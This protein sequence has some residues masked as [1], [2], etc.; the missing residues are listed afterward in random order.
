MREDP[1]TEKA[2]N[3]V[4][5]CSDR[6]VKAVAF[7]VRGSLLI[8]V[9]TALAGGEGWTLGLPAVLASTWLSLR[10]APPSKHRLQIRAIPDFVGWFLVQSLR[11]GWDVARRT[12]HPAMPIAPGLLTMTVRLPDGAPVWWLML[13]V[14]LLPG[15]LSVALSGKQ[16]E[17]HCLDINHAVAEDLAH[18]EQVLARLFGLEGYQT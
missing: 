4:A 5:C 11:A 18:T 10:L 3:S 17:V 8:L 2:L 6:S 12:C 9:W 1:K 15:T 16:L 13:V 14:S 7:C